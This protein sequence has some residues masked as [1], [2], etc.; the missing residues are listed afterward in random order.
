MK[1]KGVPTLIDPPGTM[2]GG[3]TQ[4]CDPASVTTLHSS[5][6]ETPV[7]PPF[8]AEMVIV[9]VIF[10]GKSEFWKVLR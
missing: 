8:L 4:F 2:I 5:L 10:N 6:T 1:V 7:R 9:Y 3:A